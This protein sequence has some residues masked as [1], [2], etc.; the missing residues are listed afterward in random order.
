MDTQW[1]GKQIEI[2]FKNPQATPRTSSKIMI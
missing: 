2:C 1:K